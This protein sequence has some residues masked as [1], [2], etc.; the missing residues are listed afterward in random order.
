MHPQL[1][2]AALPAT[3]PPRRT[4]SL[5]GLA[6]VLAVLLLSACAGAPTLDRDAQAD[7]EARQ[8]AAA[9]RHREAA[10]RWVRLAAQA[11]GDTAQLYRLSAADSLL[12][13]GDRAAASRLLSDVRA[14]GV[15]SALKLKADLVTARL[16]L[17]E[18]R[19]EEALKTLAG[20]YSE[21]SP[22]EQLWQARVL[23]ADALA[24]L[25]R[26]LEA[27][28][29]R[30]TA[31]RY[32]YDDVQLN[33]N[34]L[35]IWDLL[36][37]V[38]ARSLREGRPAPPDPLGGWLELADLYRTQGRRPQA[39]AQ[40]LDGWRARY[41]RHPAEIE[42]VPELLD[43]ARAREGMPS[44]IALLLPETG[45]FA[46]AARAV[47]EGFLAAWFGPGAGGGGPRVSMYDATP[48]TLSEALGRALEAGA[49]FIVGPLDKQSVTRLAAGSAPPIPV[50]A[51]NR[52]DGADAG[53]PGDPAAR[54]LYQFALA[55]EDEA[56]EVA[57]RARADGRQRAVVLYPE[58]EWG[59]RVRG[60]FQETWTSLGGE[61]IAQ[62][63]YG[64]SADAMASAV[65][66][67]LRSAAQGA[68]DR[69]FDAVF[70]AAFPPQ[71]RQLRPQLAYQAGADVPVYATSHVYAGVPSPTQDLDLEG[72][73]FG[74]MPWVLQPAAVEPGLQGALERH[75]RELR[76]GYNRLLAMGVDAY[77]LL[78]TLE[79]L[80]T[81]PGAH[82]DGV[83]GRLSVGADRHV[84]RELTWAQ[85]RSGSP[86]VLE[87]IGVRP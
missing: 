24:R 17:A 15:S 82:V 9:G 43:M 57:R 65:Q 56:R 20:P 28:R 11:R 26:P 59:E 7:A 10:D 60:A 87:P 83:S 74:D 85:F 12:Q 30:V 16:A 1:P 76:E 14:R 35:T 84:I 67:L 78:P 51:L 69:G 61:T 50:L 3:P 81:S 41:P 8:L 47:R 68:P 2:S 66:S 22:P 77:R 49:D 58:S 45:P 79:R 42:L 34:R 52:T 6:L 37:K 39:F 73:V 80:G 71:A 31:E 23:R 48:E 18:G 55:P 70:M 21:R 54:G 63:A 29:E 13:A 4:H 5:A 62:A 72:V 53:R 25:D 38:P 33:R 86:T 64:T 40:S 44:H 32:A 46:T 75:R 27:V 19:A 36:D